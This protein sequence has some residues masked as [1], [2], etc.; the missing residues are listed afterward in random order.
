MLLHTNA[1]DVYV[2]QAP[3]FVTPRW[4][5]LQVAPCVGHSYSL[6]AFGWTEDAAQTEEHQ[7]NI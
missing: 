4:D 1:W 5:V 2:R 6:E 3:S 7:V